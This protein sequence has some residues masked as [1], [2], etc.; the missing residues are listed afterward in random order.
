MKIDRNNLSLY[1]ILFVAFLNYMGIG[2]IY[3]V[4]ASLLFDRS[5]NF[6]HPETSDLIRGLYLG[7]LISLMPLMQF[8]FSPLFG[9]ISDLKGRKTVLMGC[10]FL[11]M[12]GYLFALVG[13]IIESMIALFIFRIIVGISAASAS[14]VQ[15][16]LVDMSIRQGQPKRFDLFNMAMGAG[17]TIGPFLGGFLSEPTFLMNGEVSTPFWFA[18]FLTIISLMLVMR[19][20]EE[21]RIDASLL[22]TPTDVKITSIKKN[23]RILLICMFI[24]TFGWSFFF[25]FI[26]LFLIGKYQY[27]SS[28]IGNFY[29]Y[30]GIFYVLSSGFL[31][32]PILQKFKAQIILLFAFLASSGYIFILSAIDNPNFL[33]AYTPFL[34]YLIALIF[35]TTS[36][37]I[38]NSAANDK[39]GSSLGTLLAV[40]S[41][42]FAI[43]PLFSGFLVGVH[44]VMP[45]FLGGLCFIIAAGVYGYF[46]SKGD[47][48]S[49]TEKVSGEKIIP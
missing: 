35:P 32:Q 28:Q 16:A 2:L 47:L 48:A 27:T 42:A 33:W 3:P 15:A 40:Q 8:F 23:I 21:T 9:R 14:V 7:I 49:D 20:F 19:Y 25:E 5:L 41:L 29:G 34:L 26:P 4:F 36:Y 44:H 31:I 30:S 13:V 38:S 12:F 17:Y 46:Y 37:L 22:I 10:L 6:L 11:A 1:F 39:Q 24:F 18:F 43:S 45:I